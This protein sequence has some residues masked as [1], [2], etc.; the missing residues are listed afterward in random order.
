[1][2][3]WHHDTSQCCLASTTNLSN[4]DRQQ[5]HGLVI[6]RCVQKHEKGKRARQGRQGPTGTHR[7][8]S[9][10]HLAQGK[11]RPVTTQHRCCHQS[12]LATHTN[13]LCCSALLLK[14]MQGVCWSS[15]PLL[16][17]NNDPA[18]S[19]HFVLRG[20]PPCRTLQQ[21]KKLKWFCVNFTA[22]A[23]I[24]QQASAVQPRGRLLLSVAVRKHI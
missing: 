23:Y 13:T 15:H 12:L 4:E 1:M 5:A 14:L 8:R 18:A 11:R 10:M 6:D 22:A 9:K 24:Q 7:W 2:A 20:V 17:Q 19:N 3:L 21:N 16:Q